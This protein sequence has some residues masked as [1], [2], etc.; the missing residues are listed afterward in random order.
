MQ[1]YEVFPTVTED[2]NDSI[3]A[4]ENVFNGFK[5]KIRQFEKQHDFDD[6]KSDDL[7]SYSK[8]RQ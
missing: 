7:N 8:Q 6:L 1:Y 2:R 4:E 5:L 3:I